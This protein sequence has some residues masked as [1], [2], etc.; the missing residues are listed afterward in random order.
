MHPEMHP[1]AP[2]TEN[3]VLL[4]LSDTA[5]AAEQRTNNEIPAE[6]RANRE[7]SGGTC[8]RSGRAQSHLTKSE[9]RAELRANSENAPGTRSKMHF[10][11]RRSNS[12]RRIRQL[13][14]I[15]AARKPREDRRRSDHGRCFQ[16]TVK[17][18]PP[19]MAAE[20]PETE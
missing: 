18:A 2:R 12:A 11:Q 6:Q 5:D 7:K 17:Q 3:R 10:F 19:G 4:W 9:P 15:K 20:N 14:D 1:D 8:C 13:P 16:S